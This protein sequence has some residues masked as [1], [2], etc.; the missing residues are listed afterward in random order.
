RVLDAIVAI[1]SAADPMY[2]F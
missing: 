1:K 2:G